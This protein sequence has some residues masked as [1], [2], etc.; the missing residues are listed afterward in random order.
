MSRSFKMGSSCRV[1]FQ[2]QA[3]LVADTCCS[4]CGSNENEKID[5]IYGRRSTLPLMAM[6]F[7]SLELFPFANFCNCKYNENRCEKQHNDW[8]SSGQLMNDVVVEE[9]IQ[10]QYNRLED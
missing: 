10:S 1:W 9:Q 4:L 6:V 2:N 3:V 7:H 5:I 8:P